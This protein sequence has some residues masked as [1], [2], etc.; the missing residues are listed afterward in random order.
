M[1]RSLFT[2]RAFIPNLSVDKGILPDIRLK[3]LKLLDDNFTN[4]ASTTVGFT[5]VGIFSR[6]IKGAF[7]AVTRR[8]NKSFVGKRS[9]SF[10]NNVV[11][12]E[13]VVNPLN[14]ISCSDL[15]LLGLK[16]QHSI[17]ST[18]FNFNGVRRSRVNSNE[19]T[20]DEESN[21]SDKQTYFFRHFGGSHKFLKAEIYVLSI[22]FFPM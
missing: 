11:G 18:H 20:G 14:G 21:G 16:S 12:S 17:V 13:F 10:N 8:K 1:L 22:F 4:H 6:L 3:Q 5:V 2:G 7:I 19:E 15:Y 9:L